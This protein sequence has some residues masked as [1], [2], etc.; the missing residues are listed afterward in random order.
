MRF[1]TRAERCKNEDLDEVRAF[2]TGV[3]GVDF[4]HFLPFKYRPGADNCRE[5][6]VVRE[7]GEIAA[8]VLN[9]PTALRVG[10]NEIGA[11][12]VGTVSV[13]EESRG[14]GYMTDMLA[15]CLIET[16]ESGAAYSILG[17]QRQRY[18]YY[19]YS[20][21]GFYTSFRVEPSSVRH[22]CGKGPSKYKLKKAEEKDA[23]LLVS[24]METLPVY[25]HRRA[26]N[27][28]TIENHDFRTPYLVYE[29]DRAVGYIDVSRGGDHIT[30]L[31]LL[32]GASVAELLL[33]FTETFGHEFLVEVNTFDSTTA[34][35][36]FE[37][38]SDWTYRPADSIAVLDFPK[39]LNAYGALGCAC[40]KMPDA[41]FTIGV[42]S[43]PFFDKIGISRA[44]VTHGS[45]EIAVR[46]GRFNAEPTNEKPDITLPYLRAVEYVFTDCAKFYPDS[47]AA[48]RALLP[49]P[50]FIP[51]AD[52]V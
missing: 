12:C 14:R 19:G 39:M 49:I 50:F 11:F 43:H 40:G 13:R 5:H 52:K 32:P 3:F 26:E 28:I 17:G 46:D 35:K 48:A 44:G 2:V 25:A 22:G 7:N 38:C 16:A 9:S 23:D 18:E 37:L 31:V 33:A 47:P 15:E 45:F 30:E 27:F 6:F 34:R 21:S 42:E 41:K 51:S 24:I 36:L 8:A 29:G 10:E 4:E 20:L 1:R